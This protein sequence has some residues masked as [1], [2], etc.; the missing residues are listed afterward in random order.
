[1]FTYLFTD[2]GVIY[3]RFGGGGGLK[4]SLLY[5]DLFYFPFFTSCMTILGCEEAFHRFNAKA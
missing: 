4:K 1:V 2:D 3:E 5:A